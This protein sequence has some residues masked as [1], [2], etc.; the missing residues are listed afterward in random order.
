MRA[1]RRHRQ[2]VGELKMAGSQHSARLV[3]RSPGDWRQ[4]RD[5][6]G[7][8]NRDDILELSLST[9]P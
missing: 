5:I 3:G 7:V 2:I 8:S 9:C 4:S 6:V 1:G